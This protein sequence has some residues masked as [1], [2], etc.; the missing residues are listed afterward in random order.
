MDQRKL[1]SPALQQEIDWLTDWLI[2]WSIDWLIDPHID[3]NVLLLVIIKHISI[4]NES[5][6][7]DSSSLPN[8]FITPKN[9]NFDEHGY[10]E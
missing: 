5:V 2:D 9:Q 3:L 1:F 6:Y 7:F 10:Y 8:V 4:F